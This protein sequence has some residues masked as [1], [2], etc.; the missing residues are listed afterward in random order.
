MKGTIIAAAALVGSLIGAVPAYAGNPQT[1]SSCQ[2][3]D[4]NMTTKSNT[5]AALRCLPNEDGTY[6]WMTDTGAKATISQLQSEGYTV[7]IDRVGT[8]P[9]DRCSVTDIRNPNTI[10]QW[11]RDGGHVTT[12]LIS[13]TIEVSLDC[14]TPTIQ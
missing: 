9:L 4:L 8:G 7:R 14:A 1:N 2:P 6:S 11:D 3:T 5:G 13:K 10:N 12:V